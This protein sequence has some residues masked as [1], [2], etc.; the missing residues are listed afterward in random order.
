MLLKLQE[1]KIL[2]QVSAASY[3]KDAT[4][5]LSKIFPADDNWNIKKQDVSEKYAQIVVRLGARL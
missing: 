3:A 1:A 4:A 5:C 2:L